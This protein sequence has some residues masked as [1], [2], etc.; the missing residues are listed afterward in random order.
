MP[1]LRQQKLAQKILENTG[2][3]AKGKPM[4]K[5]MVEAGYSP[6]TAKNPHQ[7]LK[8]PIIQDALDPF[9]K[10][11]MKERDHIINLL[12]KRRRFAGFSDLITGLDK[13]TKNI[14]L[15]TGG[16]TENLGIDTY[17]DSLNEL[18]KEIKD[19]KK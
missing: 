15:L 9:V 2:K 17:V 1:T 16:Q 8:S 11:M 18:M 10:K 5:L 13:L 12:P 3:S 7:I 6:E 14:Q 19:S 4:G